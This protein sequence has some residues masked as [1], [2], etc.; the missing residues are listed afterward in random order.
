[1]WWQLQHTEGVPSVVVVA[2]HRWVPS[3][4]AVAA[5]R[6]VPSVVVVLAE[7]LCGQDWW[8]SMRTAFVLFRAAPPLQSQV[9][10]PSGLLA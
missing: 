2:T 8:V 6:W 7:S 1:M 3:V 5:H 9:Q 10:E 4:V